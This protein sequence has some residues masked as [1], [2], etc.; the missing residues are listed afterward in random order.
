VRA[1]LLVLALGTCEHTLA[2]EETGAVAGTHGPTEVP[3]I[4][5]EAPPPPAESGPFWQPTEARRAVPILR[6]DAPSM[7]YAALDRDACLR[8]LG[9]RGVS[10]VLAEPTTGVMA[11]VR[12]RGA[13]AGGVTIHSMLGPAERARAPLEI[14]DCRLVLALD[15]FSAMVA[16]RGIVEMIHLSGYRPR[17]QFGCTPKYDGKQH[18]AALAVDIAAFK[19]SDGSVL[20]VERD[21]HGRVGLSTC[22]AR[23]APN[24]LWSIVCDAAD[25]GLFNVILSPNYNAQHFNHLH[26]EVT[27]QA[28]WMLV[29]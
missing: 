15:D 16:K 20:S 13:L 17:S 19:R 14:F 12:L 26:V 8:E 23:P 21:F 25:R 27:P 11:P 1:T 24:E 3:M 2:V 28:A 10:F 7:R 29:P 4:A 18:C 9:R 22:T 5:V 6:S